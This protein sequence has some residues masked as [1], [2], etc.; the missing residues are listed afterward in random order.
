MK[1]GRDIIGSRGS[2]EKLR[3]QSLHSML[4]VRFPLDAL[5]EVYHY[6]KDYKAPVSTA[7]IAFELGAETSREHKTIVHGVKKGLVVAE[8]ALS[9]LKSK[10]MVKR[11][12]YGGWIVTPRGMK[13][14]RQAK[15]VWEPYQKYKERL[16]GK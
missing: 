8:N 2:V 9:V 10:G 15:H 5:F 1:M 16:E 12:K 11:T 13:I 14:L 4:R 7:D 3:K 6:Q